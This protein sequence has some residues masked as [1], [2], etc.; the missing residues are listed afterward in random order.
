MEALKEWYSPEELQQAMFIADS[1]FV[2]K[3]NLQAAK[4]DFR[5]VSC[6]PE[7]F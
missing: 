6:L 1:A 5:F 4:P 7:N 3:D 2:T